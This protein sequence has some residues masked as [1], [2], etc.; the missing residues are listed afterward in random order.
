MKQ[1]NDSQAS[2]VEPPAEQQSLRKFLETV[3]DRIWVVVAA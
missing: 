3:R 2:W 1:I